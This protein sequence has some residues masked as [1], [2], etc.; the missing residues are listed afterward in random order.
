M[1]R[2][3]KHTESSRNKQQPNQSQEENPT[4]VL[5]EAVPEIGEVIKKSPDVERVFR[6]HPEL[7]STI[8]TTQVY[9]GPVPHPSLMK[10]FDKIIPGAAKQMLDDAMK[11]SESQRKINED[12]VK[13]KNKEVARGQWFGFISVIALIS[14]VTF[15]TISGFTVGAG[16]IAGIATLGGAFMW[17]KARNKGQ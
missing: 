14:A 15:I 16:V 1:S 3:N 6:K 2:N 13:Y 11:N 4:D 7:S 8:L 10:E 9:S 12:I 5:A 17:A